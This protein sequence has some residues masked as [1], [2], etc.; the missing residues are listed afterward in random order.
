MI[1]VINTQQNPANAEAHQPAGGRRLVFKRPEDLQP[2]DAIVS[3]SGGAT[4]FDY[5]SEVRSFG[6]RDVRVDVNVWTGANIY[7]RDDEVLV[8]SAHSRDAARA[9]RE[10]R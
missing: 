10:R 8:S 6:P 2:G 5:V 1:T 3:L 9:S 7:K 4:A